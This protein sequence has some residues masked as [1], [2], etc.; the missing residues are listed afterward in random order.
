MWKLMM[1]RIF[2]IDIPINIPRCYGKLIN[3]FALEIVNALIGHVDVDI[4]NELD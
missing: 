2:D 4:Y 3:Y 1:S